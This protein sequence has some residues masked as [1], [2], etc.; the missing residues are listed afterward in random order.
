MKALGVLT[1]R[2]GDNDVV[3]KEGV[4]ILTLHPDGEVSGL[5]PF[6]MEGPSPVDGPHR[7]VKQDGALWQSREHAIRQAAVAAAGGGATGEEVRSQKFSSLPPPSRA[8][9]LPR[10]GA[11]QAGQGDVLPEG[12]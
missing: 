10:E 2:D 4:S 3:S 8:P 5:I 6:L 7:L 1:Q 9:C 11:V 12:L